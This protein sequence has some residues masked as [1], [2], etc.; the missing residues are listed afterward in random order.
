MLEKDKVEAVLFDLD[1]TLMDTDDQAVEKLAHR[2][3]RLRW[4]HP[5]QAARRFV[6]AAE[7]PGNALMTLI[8]MLGLDGPLAALT[9]RLHHWRG[10]RARADFRIVADAEEMLDA[11]KGRYRLAVVTTRGRRDAEA[12]LGQHNLH[13]YFDALVTR[14]STWRLKPHPAPVRRAAQLLDVPVEQ[15]VMVGDTPV[16]VKSARRAGAWAVAV[17]CGFGERGEL[18][19]AGAHVVLEHTSHCSSLL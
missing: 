17:L 12:F 2:L 14:E 15:C 18:E 10:L 1:G 5:H 7:T 16:D 19:R 3:E 9:D 13:D 11:L 6:M 8:D 4:P